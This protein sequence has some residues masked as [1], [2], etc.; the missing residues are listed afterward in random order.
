VVTSAI[1]VRNQHGKPVMAYTAT[2]MLAGR[3]G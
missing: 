1:E 2:R 3:P